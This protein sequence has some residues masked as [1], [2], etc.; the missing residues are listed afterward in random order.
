MNSA[1]S[2]LRGISIGKPGVWR[3]PATGEGSLRKEAGDENVR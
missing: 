2:Y 3:S 1:I